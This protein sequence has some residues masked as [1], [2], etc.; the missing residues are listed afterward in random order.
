MT[1]IQEGGGCKR[2]K[3]RGLPTPPSPESIVVANNDHTFGSFTKSASQFTPA[4]TDATDEYN[5]GAYAAVV[6]SVDSGEQ[7][8]PCCDLPPTVPD[9]LIFIQNKLPER[10]GRYMLH[11]YTLPGLIQSISKSKEIWVRQHKDPSLFAAIV[12]FNIMEQ[13]EDTPRLP[14]DHVKLFDD[15]LL[16]MIN[17]VFQTSIESGWYGYVLYLCVCVLFLFLCC[18]CFYV[19]DQGKQVQLGLHVCCCSY[20]YDSQRAHDLI[21][22]SLSR[23]F[24]HT[25]HLRPAYNCPCDSLMRR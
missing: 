10:M 21:A 13:Y 25:L 6:A 12:A 4:Q 23:L 8:P 22:A 24:V 16:D 15:H 20:R 3:S 5:R 14:G 19:Y 7:V 17:I 2:H 11:M 1:E 9:K 18:S